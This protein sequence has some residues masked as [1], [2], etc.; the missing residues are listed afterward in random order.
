MRFT[1]IA[2][3]LYVARRADGVSFGVGGSRG[4]WTLMRI[5]TGKEAKDIGVYRTVAAAF[6]AAEEAE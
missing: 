6:A 1:R 5:E 2:R 3:G 4:E